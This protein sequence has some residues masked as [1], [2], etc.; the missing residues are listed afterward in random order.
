MP[1]RN[2]DAL[3]PIRARRKHGLSPRLA[4]LSLQWLAALIRRSAAGQG[5]RECCRCC[6]CC[7]RCCCGCCRW[8]CCGRRVGGAAVDSLALHFNGEDSCSCLGNE[9]RRV[10]AIVV[11]INSLVNPSRPRLGPQGTRSARRTRARSTETPCL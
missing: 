2:I 4:L 7:R 8:C 1:A 9:R 10:A 11:L 6:G 5:R 3:R